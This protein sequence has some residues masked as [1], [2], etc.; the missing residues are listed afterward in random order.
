MLTSDSEQLDWGTG[1]LPVLNHWLFEMLQDEGTRED[2]L[3]RLKSVMAPMIEQEGSHEVERVR[4]FVACRTEG[5][6]NGRALL[7]GN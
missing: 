7:N 5:V 2:V 1:E 3:E 6:E 4:Q